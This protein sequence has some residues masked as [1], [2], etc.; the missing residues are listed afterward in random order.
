MNVIGELIEVIADKAGLNGIR[1][2]GEVLKTGRRS[3]DMPTGIPLDERNTMVAAVVGSDVLEFGQMLIGKLKS[4]TGEGTPNTGAL[5]AHGHAGFNK[6]GETLRSAGRN[7]SW[8]GS[9]S[10]AY[11]DQNTRQQLRTET[12]ADADLAVHRVLF[13]EAAQIT[14]RRHGLDRQSDLLGYT[15]YATFPLQFIPRFG[16]AAKLDIEIK[17]VQAALGVSAYLL[18]QLHSEVNANAAELQQAVGRY[19]GV[20]DGADMPGADIDFGKGEDINVPR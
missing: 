13:R 7:D 11:A 15:S 5:M 12:M 20:A 4:T 9:G 3:S 19:A 2:V 14:L 1:E 10:R 16:E 8:A 17:A 18:Y 6:T